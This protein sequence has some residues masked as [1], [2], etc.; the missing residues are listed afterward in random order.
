MTEQHTTGAPDAAEQESQ[1]RAGASDA[2]EHDNHEGDA[3]GVAQPERT[4]DDRP[5]GHRLFWALLAVG[6]LL[7]L[8]VVVVAG[9]AAGWGYAIAVAIVIVIALLF[10][11]AHSLIGRYKT[12]RYGEHMRDVVAERGDDPIPHMGFDDETALG[13]TAQQSD[14]DSHSEIGHSTGAR[15]N[16]TLG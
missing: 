5:Q 4:N 13:D 1:Q 7:G 2:A 16:S 9:A 12:R 11:A 6:V 10:V 8:A 15:H 14:L 3:S